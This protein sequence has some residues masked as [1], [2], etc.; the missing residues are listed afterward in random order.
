MRNTTGTEGLLGAL[1][2]LVGIAI[3]ALESLV[4]AGGNAVVLAGTGLL[5]YGLTSS[6]MDA[7][8]LSGS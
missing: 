5:A 7:I 8:G 4:V 1:L 6:F 2:A 3:V